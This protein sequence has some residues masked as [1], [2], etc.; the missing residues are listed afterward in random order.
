MLESLVYLVNN[1]EDSLKGGTHIQ[2]ANLFLETIVTK[3]II[4]LK[5]NIKVY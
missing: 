5:Y 4:A 1:A 2:E 3:I